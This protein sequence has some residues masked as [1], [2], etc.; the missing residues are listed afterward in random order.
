MGRGLLRVGEEILPGL[1]VTKP[2]PAVFVVAHHEPERIAVQ[3]EPAVDRGEAR[4][5]PVAV[6]YRFLEG[7]GL[8]SVRLRVTASR[9]T[10]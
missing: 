5:R 7:E 4:Q 8:D 10:R 1:R 3:A 6:R 2:Q 9:L